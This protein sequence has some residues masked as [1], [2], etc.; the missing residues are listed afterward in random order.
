MKKA[1]KN[2]ERL[3]TTKVPK[4][5]LEKKRFNNSEICILKYV[6][7]M[8]PMEIEAKLLKLWKALEKEAIFFLA[9]QFWRSHIEGGEGGERARRLP[10]KKSWATP[11]MKAGQDP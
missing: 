9:N 1:K 8:A 5:F 2:V 4:Y 6:P 3:F 7:N 10:R 11:W